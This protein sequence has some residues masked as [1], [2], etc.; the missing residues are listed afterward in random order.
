MKITMLESR[1]SYKGGGS[2][3]KT[4]ERHQA[5]AAAEARDKERKKARD[6]KKGSV[7]SKNSKAK[8]NGK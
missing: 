4:S 5:R 2:P 3:M 7:N 6:L 8:K 1:L